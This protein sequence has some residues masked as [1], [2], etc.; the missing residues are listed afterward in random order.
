LTGFVSVLLT[1]FLA[2]AIPLGAQAHGRNAVSSD[3]ELLE[4]YQAGL[5]AYLKREYAVALKKWRP[6]AEREA[7]SSA[8]QLFLGFMTFQGQGV[9]RNPSAAAEW[10]RRSADQDNM[11][12]QLRL[13]FL[14]RH[15]EGV[16]KDLI[17]AYL[18]A[19]LAARQK[20]HVQ[21]IAQTLQE[22][23][24]KSMTPA[25][26]GEAKRLAKEWKNGH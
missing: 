18:W 19:S 10:Y 21:K 8:A 7:E 22:T 3:P 26:I 23:L 6:L 11:L 20:S 5:H 13:A 16:P 14:Y 1:V 2:L 17:R 4:Q 24:S 15:G 9:P 25:Q 12:A